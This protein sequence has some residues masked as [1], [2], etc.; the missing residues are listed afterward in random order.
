VSL[1]FLVPL[2]RQTPLRA[3]CTPMKARRGAA[4]PVVREDE[5]VAR[6]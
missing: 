2:F 5:L 4:K 3:V 6:G 1:L